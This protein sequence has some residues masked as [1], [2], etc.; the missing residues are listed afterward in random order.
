MPRQRGATSAPTKPEF[1]FEQRCDALNAVHTD[2][3]GG[4]FE[5]ERDAIESAADFRDDRRVLIIQFEWV[6]A[7]SDVLDEE[8]YRREGQRL[9]CGE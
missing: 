6:A 7:G 2:T 8:L 1:A 4:E 9:R 5:G 3:A